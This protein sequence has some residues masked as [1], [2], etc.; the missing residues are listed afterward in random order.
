MAATRLLIGM[1]RLSL[2][3]KR[4]CSKIG[5]SPAG[6]FAPIYRRIWQ[7]EAISA[8]LLTPWRAARKPRPGE[9]VAQMV[10]HLTFN[11][12][13]LGSSPSALTNIPR[14]IEIA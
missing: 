6:F 8:A 5:L 11:Q 4:Q 1:G 14:F 3:M 10:E 7:P 9:R 2:G 12:V 13:V